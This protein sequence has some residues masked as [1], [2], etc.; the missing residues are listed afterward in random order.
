MSWHW[1]VVAL[2][3]PVLLQ[4]YFHKQVK[5][6]PQPKWLF[7]LLFVFGGLA[8]GPALLLNHLVEKYS[9]LWPFASLE[10]WRNLFWVW[11][12][13][14]NEE[15][16]KFLVFL[17]FL[18]PR[19]DF[20]SL[21]Q[22]LL[23]AMAVAAGFAFVENLVYFERYGGGVLLLRSFTTVPV[24]MSFGVPLAVGAFW[25]KTSSSGFTSWL[26]LCLGLLLA[27]LSHGA[28]DMGLSSSNQVGAYLGYGLVLFLCLFLVWALCFRR[29]NN[30][31]EAI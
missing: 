4:V 14:P 9:A 6:V 28:Y 12:V 15:F 3:V 18:Y 7:L 17:C 27:A 19:K 20:R 24:H 11:G 31:Q 29:E 2:F 21:E 26:W 23:G 5:V 30:Q 25:A 13:G 8:T 22:G 10:L 1:L 16:S